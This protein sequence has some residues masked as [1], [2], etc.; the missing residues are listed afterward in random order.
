[1]SVAASSGSFAARADNLKLSRHVGLRLLPKV[2]VR[3]FVSEH[4]EGLDAVIELRVNESRGGEEVRFTMR[5]KDN[6]L[7]VSRGAAPDARA[8]LSGGLNDF[9]L[10]ASGAAPWTELL[11][12]GRLQLG[13]DPFTALRVP[14]LLNF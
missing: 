11:A 7:A 8:W 12:S 13:G 9:V 6:Q 14:V 5:V 3:R 1:M 10:I 2:L 4:A